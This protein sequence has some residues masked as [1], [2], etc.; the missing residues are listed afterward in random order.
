MQSKQSS[1]DFCAIADHL[2]DENRTLAINPWTTTHVQL[3]EKERLESG[4][5]PVRM[6]SFLRGASTHVRYQDLVR[7]SVGIEH[8]E[9]I[10]TDLDQ[11]LRGVGD[12]AI[13]ERTSKL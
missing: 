7:I 13:K 4:V 3:T 10:I 5:T 6:N 8:I 2:R 12:G 11:A 9:D 1:I